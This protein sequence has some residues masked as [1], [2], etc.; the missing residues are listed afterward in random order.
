MPVLTTPDLMAD[1]ADAITNGFAAV[2]GCVEHRGE[3]HPTVNG[4]RG[5]CCTFKRGM[6]WFQK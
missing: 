1:S 3:P 2:F 6:C 5:K 4:K